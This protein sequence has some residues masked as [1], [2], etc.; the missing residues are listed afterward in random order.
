MP[1]SCKT[2]SKDTHLCSL[3]LHFPCCEQ[4]CRATPMQALHR[5]HSQ[6]VNDTGKH[7]LIEN[8]HSFLHY[9]M[10]KALNETEIRSHTWM[11]WMMLINILCSLKFNKIV[12]KN[13][14]SCV[15]S[16]FEMS[17]QRENSPCSS[18][19]RFVAVCIPFVL[20]GTARTS[21]VSFNKTAGKNCSKS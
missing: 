19:M 1:G 2:F 12:T 20:R 7:S 11:Q 21:E 17:L 3:M 15:Q 6:Q 8:K 18:R 13:P 5:L 14:S 10:K 4:N 9:V 16:L